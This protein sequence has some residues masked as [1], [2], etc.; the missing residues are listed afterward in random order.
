MIFISNG[1]KKWNLL[2]YNQ[3]WLKLPPNNKLKKKKFKNSKMLSST[4]SS[5][6]MKSLPNS[7]Q[8][9]KKK[10]MKKMKTLGLNK[11]ENNYYVLP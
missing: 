4:H 9:M 10:E 1:Q 2:L 7:N 8:M 6:K 5:P 3:P 11:H